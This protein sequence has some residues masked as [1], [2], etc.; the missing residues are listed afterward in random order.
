MQVPKQPELNRFL[1]IREK[2]VVDHPD[3]EDFDKAA[4]LMATLEANGGQMPTEQ[5][6][7]TAQSFYNTYAHDLALSDAIDKGWM[8]VSGTKNGQLTY[9]LTEKGRAHAKNLTKKFQ[10]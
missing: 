1:A 8:K 10:T 7:E 6:L 4:A 5:L 2:L 9:S 3:M